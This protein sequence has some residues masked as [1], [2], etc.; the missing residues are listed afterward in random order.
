MKLDPIQ[1]IGSAQGDPGVRER[2]TGPEKGAEDSTWPQSVQLLLGRCGVH[3]PTCEPGLD[4]DLLCLMGC[5]EKDTI[6]VPEPRPQH[7]F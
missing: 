7:T 1:D 3:V 6:M 5:G 2:Q 4:L